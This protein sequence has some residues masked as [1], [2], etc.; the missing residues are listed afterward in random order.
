M[1]RRTYIPDD[2]HLKR[3][4]DVEDCGKWAVLEWNGSWFCELH[5][6]DGPRQSEVEGQQDLFGGEV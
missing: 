3:E 4:C 1:T 6:Y 5:Y 2:V